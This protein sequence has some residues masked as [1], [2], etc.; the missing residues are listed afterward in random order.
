MLERL[1]YLLIQTQAYLWHC[2]SNAENNK[3]FITLTLGWHVQRWNRVSE[4]GGHRES[5][6]HRQPYNSSGSPGK[7]S[8]IITR[9][10]NRR[11]CA[12]IYAYIMN[13]V[14]IN[15]PARTNFL[16]LHIQLWA[17]FS[18]KTT[19]VVDFHYFNDFVKKYHND[20]Y[21]VRSRR[22]FRPRNSK[23]NGSFCVF[24]QLETILSAL[25]DFSVVVREKL[26]LMLQVFKWFSNFCFPPKTQVL[27]QI[28]WLQCALG[29]TF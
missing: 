11:P 7:S 19:Y 23:H 20:C 24:F 14:S 27:F 15:F 5:H 16:S 18:C 22:L 26:H 17:H 25:D 9:K 12:R 2:A 29:S 1:I 10:N 13:S 6:P 8:F 28:Q 21:W 4:A 3:N